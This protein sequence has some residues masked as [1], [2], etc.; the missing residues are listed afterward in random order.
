[1]A[2][3]TVSA[4]REIF[5]EKVE[6]LQAAVDGLPTEALNWRPAGD[7]T[8]PLAVLAIHAMGST[9]NWLAVALGAPRPERDR[10]AE[11]LTVAGEG[12]ELLAHVD[13]MAEDCRQLFDDAGPFQPDA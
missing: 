3:P 13:R 12:P 7:D 1:M 11:F 6:G 2:D 5:E 10:S 8:N 9:R 4:A